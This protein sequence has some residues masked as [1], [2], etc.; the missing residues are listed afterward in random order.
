MEILT[1]AIEKKAEHNVILGQSHFIKTVADI[2]EAI[3]NINPAIQYGLAFAEAS[4]PCLIRQAGNVAELTD[5]AV[6][7]IQNLSAGHAFILVMGSGYPINLLPA[8]KAL[9]EVC[10]I[11]CA[12]ANPVQ[13]IV[14]DTPTGRGILG[15]IDG[16]GPKGVET[17]EQAV[18]R[19]QL[20]KSFGYKF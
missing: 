10:T 3:A 9:P 16:E 12:S 6:K 5:L 1:V 11:Y 18:Q 7:N 15:V 13:V 19:S 8:L 14:A 4:G 2:Q 20:L 17:P